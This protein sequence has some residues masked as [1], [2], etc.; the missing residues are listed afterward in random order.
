M[1]AVV[2]DTQHLFRRLATD[3]ERKLDR[4]HLFALWH[5]RWQADWREAEETGN[6][7]RLGYLARERDTMESL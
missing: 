3:D 7:E 6:A 5:W 2:I 4:K 1:S